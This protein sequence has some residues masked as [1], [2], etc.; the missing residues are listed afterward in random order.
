V[1]NWQ[2][3]QRKSRKAEW[4]ARI[5][6]LFLVLFVLTLLFH[7]TGMPRFEIVIPTYE[8]NLGFAHLSTP[9]LRQFVGPLKQ[10]STPTAMKLLGVAITA[11][12]VAVGLGMAAFVSI[13]RE[14]Q[15]GA[16]NAVIGVLVGAAMLS[17][18][19][20]SLPNLLILPRLH[21]V[22]TDTTRPP[23]FQVLAE[24]RRA[25][26]AN[27]VIFQRKRATLQTAAYPDIKPLTIRRPPAEAY[28]VVQKA[29]E[30]LNWEVVGTPK[31]PTPARSGKIEATA[32]SLLFGLTD[33]L[34]IRITTQSS[35]DTRVDV[36]S[37]SRYGEHD[38]GRNAE[39][40]R[41]FYS[42]VKTRLGEIERKERLARALAIRKI[43]VK[44]ALARKK[45]A[46]EARLRKERAERRAAARA[47]RKA[48]I[49]RANQAARD[50]S[51]SRSRPSYQDDQERRRRRR[52]RGS[53]P[54]LRRFWE[55][56]IR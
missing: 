46:K 40:I 29:V 15:T 24:R 23:A 31:S 10:I 14:G 2:H 22:S 13:W 27:P 44:E 16:G 30:R 49:E 21:E 45:A 19:L 33:D 35:Y 6:L 3:L 18:P 38:L 1:Q 39:H 4:S 47:R 32:R 7:R 8:V 43:R 48:E 37:S 53:R 20:L 56:L 54:N 26:G 9:E 55:R 11:A 17:M 25:I 5:A 52:S 34:V 28:A 12:V 36:R 42:E 50:G 41:D 51:R